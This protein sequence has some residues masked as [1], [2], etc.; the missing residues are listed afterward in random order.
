MLK[1]I[2]VR[3]G[4]ITLP[5]TFVGFDEMNQLRKLQDGLIKTNTIDYWH[6]T[7]IV[8]KVCDGELDPKVASYSERVY[9]DGSKSPIGKRL[10]L[11]GEEIAAVLFGVT[12]CY[13]E[14]LVERKRYCLEHISKGALTKEEEE[15]IEKE[16]V[17]LDEKIKTFPRE[18]NQINDR[19]YKTILTQETVDPDS[20][21]F[22]EEI[23]LE[24][25]LVDP[26]TVSID[27]VAEPELPTPQTIEELKEKLKRLQEVKK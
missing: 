10:M 6:L 19:V 26:A 22:T 2:S 25:E 14:Q 12:L 11:H 1:L 17:G 24:K 7:D 15:A 4:E 23:E 3:N 9:P 20:I 13:I 5:I 8:C 21:K 18:I 27:V 16:V